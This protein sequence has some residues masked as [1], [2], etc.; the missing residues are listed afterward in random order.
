MAIL[1]IT[2]LQTNFNYKLLNDFV[3]KIGL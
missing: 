1:N 2:Y 3:V